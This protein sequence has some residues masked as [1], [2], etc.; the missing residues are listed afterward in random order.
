MKKIALII[1]ILTILIAI[2][3]FLFY[4]VNA[5]GKLDRQKYVQSTTPTLFFHGY[6]SSAN[7]ERHMT[8]AAKKAGVTKTVIRANV[9]RN[10]AVTLGG[11]IPKG[12]I[13]PI[14]EVN[15][16]DNRNPNKVSQYA[17]AV[18]TKLQQT[19]GFKKMNMVG[20]SL[21]NMS[22]LYYLLD[23]GQ[24]EKLPQLQ[25]Q[26]NIANFAAGLEAMGLPAD[27][28]VDKTTGKPN[29]VTQTFQRLLPL[30]EVF[31]QNQI[32]VLNI[33]GDYKNGSD[34]SV[35][36]ASSRSLK[37]L[38]AD[39]AKSYQEKKIIG[40]LAQHSQLHENPEVDKILIQFLW[41][42]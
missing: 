14:V 12:A 34:G 42:K 33:Y 26:V 35:L 8:D 32:D 29:Q 28:K 20:H 39:N 27:V 3:T 15:Y 24:D 22:I 13:N 9:D 41:G 1:G 11:D 37:Y 16:E 30:R 18:V 21:G 19:Y 36:N 6:G 2:S 17:K 7:A 23:H 40:K 5:E 4:R 10:G 38:V 25:K 31:P